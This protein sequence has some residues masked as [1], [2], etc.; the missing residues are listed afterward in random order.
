MNLIQNPTFRTIK[1]QKPSKRGLQRGVPQSRIDKFMSY[2]TSRNDPHAEILDFF[3]YC[4][5][6]EKE[7]HSF[8]QDPDMG[9]NC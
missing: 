4:A 7:D 8:L 2:I 1:I 5:V 3:P 9:W 6:L